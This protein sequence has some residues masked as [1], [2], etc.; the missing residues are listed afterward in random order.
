MDH[1][2][3]C[4]L[5]CRHPLCAFKT[6]VAVHLKV[7]D[8]LMLERMLEQ[9]ENTLTRTYTTDRGLR[10]ILLVRIITSMRRP[11]LPSDHHCQR[12]ALYIP[13]H[14][15]TPHTLPSRF[16]RRLPDT[17]AQGLRVS[18]SKPSANAHALKTVESGK[19]DSGL[20]SD[21]AKVD[22]LV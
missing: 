2:D 11:L 14:L 15:F 21:G 6:E 8:Q 20:A 17:R 7:T 18:A 22:S 9:R 19:K 4:C 5:P 16:T 3:K 12:T 1:K 13:L 10:N